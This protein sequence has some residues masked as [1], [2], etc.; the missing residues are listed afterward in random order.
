[1]SALFDKL[2]IQGFVVIA[3]IGVNYYDIAKEYNMDN[4]EAAKWMCKEAYLAGADAVKFQTYKAEKIA[5]KFSPAY[6]SLEEENTLSQY[7]LFK[8]YDFFGESEYRELSNYCKELGVVF[9]STPFDFEAVDYLDDVMDEYKISSSDLTNIPFIEY[10]CK[11]GKPI[12]L[13]VGAA[14]EE[15]IDL[16]VSVINSYGNHLALLHCVLEYPTPLED[17]NLLR[18]VALKQKY[19]NIEIGYSDHTKP[20]DDYRVIRI[21][22]SLGG[23]IIEKHFTLNK[24]LK[25]NDHYHAMDVNDL[26]RIRKILLE[27][28][29]VLGDA[30]IDC[31]NAED[32]ARKNARRSIVAA[33]DI[34]VGDVID[35][36]CLTFK[37]PGNGI[38]PKFYSNIVGKKAVKN[39]NVDRILN[40]EDIANE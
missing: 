38:S 21:A 27:T 22:F 39:V 33:K 8:K 5:S 24:T 26:R 14:K 17:A 9:M 11:K 16:A 23:S 40:W 28:K 19:K 34:K 1:M 10:I 30:N 3:E 12:I 13:S 25:G 18:I 2:A 7:E 32:L 4:I 15:E 29:Q 20:T 37:R 6:W 36:S 35:A 31:T